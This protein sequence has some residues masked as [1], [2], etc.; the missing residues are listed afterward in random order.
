VVKK[1][2]APKPTVAPTPPP[3]EPTPA[4]EEDTGDKNPGMTNDV[5]FVPA[6]TP[7]PSD[8][9]QAPLSVEDQEAKDK[10][11]YHEIKAQ[12]LEDK[13]IKA[14]KEKADNATS[15]DAEHEAELQYNK[16]L[17]RKLRAMDPSISDYIDRMEKAT[18]KRI[19]GGE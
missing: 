12:A 16:A 4:K 1:T 11:R 9:A 7:P 6:A 10:A 14:L 3:P 5:P 2:P 8:T 15:D 18:M 19:G 13:E 17:F